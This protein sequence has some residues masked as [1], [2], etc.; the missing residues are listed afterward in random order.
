[1]LTIVKMIACTFCFSGSF[2][3]TWWGRGTL[4][5]VREKHTVLC[6]C[7]LFIFGGGNVGFISVKCIQH[8]RAHGDHAVNVNDELNITDKN[9][10]KICDSFRHKRL[11]AKY[12]M[13]K[14]RNV[15]LDL[16]RE[17][18]VLYDAVFDTI[19]RL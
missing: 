11:M 1:M 17:F 13:E 6:W 5:L 12:N 9:K 15:T 4:K 7:L 14:H 16:D 18:F 8:S 2:S 3:L 10:Y 19:K